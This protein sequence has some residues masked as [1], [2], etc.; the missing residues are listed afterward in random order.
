MKGTPSLLVRGA[1]SPRQKMVA[2]LLKISLMVILENV[3]LE[4]NSVPDTMMQAFENYGRSSTKKAKLADAFEVV[5]MPCREIMRAQGSINKHLM[6]KWNPESP[7][8]LTKRLSS[9]AVEAQT[10]VQQTKDLC[11]CIA[12]LQ[13]HLNA[14]SR[15]VEMQSSGT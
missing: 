8:E 1:D 9:P 7:W 2:H 3:L 12:E 15:Q 4:G 11:V 13:R 14:Q 6:A 5:L 10:V